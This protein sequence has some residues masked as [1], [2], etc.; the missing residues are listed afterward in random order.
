MTPRS[1]FFVAKIG[2]NSTKPN[3]GCNRK[4]CLMPVLPQEIRPKK[5]IINSFYSGSRE[6]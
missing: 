1:E 4:L 5:G 2:V 3:G 6:K